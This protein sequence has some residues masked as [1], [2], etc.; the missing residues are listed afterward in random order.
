M[1]AAI[2]KEKFDQSYDNRFPVIISVIVVVMISTINEEWFP[3][4]R[5]D[6]WAA[7]FVAIVAMIRNPAV[8]N[9]N[10]S[11]LSKLSTATIIWLFWPCKNDV[12]SFWIYFFLLVMF[13]KLM[14][15]L[16]GSVWSFLVLG[17]A[18]KARRSQM[19]SSSSIWALPKF[20]FS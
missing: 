14:L 3:Y 19:G 20:H 16:P 15:L 2:A 13:L 6:C 11:L 12:I 17:L 4:D 1:T 18:H 9:H 7:I 5:N 8:N 10:F